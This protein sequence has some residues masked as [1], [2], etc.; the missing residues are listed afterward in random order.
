[1]FDENLA[2][3]IRSG[4]FEESDLFGND[5]DMFFLGG[6]RLHMPLNW[7]RLNLLRVRGVIVML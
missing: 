2:V 4:L 5:S 7:K 6:G 1:M 3:E